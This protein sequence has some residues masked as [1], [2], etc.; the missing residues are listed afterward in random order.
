[1]AECAFSHG[2][3][4]APE[5]LQHMLNSS[6]VIDLTKVQDRTSIAM[7]IK[8]CNVS[9]EYDSDGYSLGN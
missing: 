3:Q 5:E 9:K 2:K 4:I 6:E 8:P 7:P 1:M